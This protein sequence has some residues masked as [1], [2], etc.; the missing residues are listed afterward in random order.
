MPSMFRA[1]IPYPDYSEFS[2]RGQWARFERVPIVSGPLFG[3]APATGQSRAQRHKVRG[4]QN[5]GHGR[6]AFRG[7]G[8]AVRTEQGVPARRNFPSAS[9][10][11]TNCGVPSSVTLW[12]AAVCSDEVQRFRADGVSGSAAAGPNPPYPVRVKTHSGRG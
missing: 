7:D 1:K 2:A 6:G 11:V 8:D 3:P 5:G 10:S 12:D 4:G 9:Q